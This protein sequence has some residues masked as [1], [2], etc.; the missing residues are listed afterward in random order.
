MAFWLD[1]EPFVV[2]RT[3]LG[4]VLYVGPLKN[5]SGSAAVMLFT[6]THETCKGDP[7]AFFCEDARLQLRQATSS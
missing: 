4:G 6:I 7:R 5:V 3:F 1:P 2:A